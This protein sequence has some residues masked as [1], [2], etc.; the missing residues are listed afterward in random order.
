MRNPSNSAFRLPAWSIALVALTLLGA[1]SCDDDDYGA[2]ATPTSPASATFVA[3]P[4][5]AASPT[6]LATIDP[7][8]TPGPAT[9]I[10]LRVVPQQLTCDGTQP[11]VVTAVVLDEANQP[12]E[13]GTV[14]NFSVVVSGSADPVNAGTV[15]GVAES[16]VTALAQGQGVVVNVSAGTAAASARID[17]L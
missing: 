3:T 16:S 14:V 12:V 11:S 15:D 4:A 2:D 13:D 7:V 5:P 9:T 17:C 6:A 10:A 8:H 1:S